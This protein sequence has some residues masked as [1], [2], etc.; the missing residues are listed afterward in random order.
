MENEIPITPMSPEDEGSGDMDNETTPP[1]TSST[2]EGSGDEYNEIPDQGAESVKN[3]SED[4]L[5][6]VTP[7]YEP[8]S[9]ESSED[10]TSAGSSPF[11]IKPELLNR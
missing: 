11:N 8:A 1:T 2:V 6:P 3:F 5:M 9:D 4:D 10:L 7:E